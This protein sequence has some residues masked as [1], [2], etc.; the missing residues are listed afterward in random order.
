MDCCCRLSTRSVGAVYVGEHIACA[1][2]RDVSAVS[3]CWTWVRCSIETATGC[4]P[5]SR[6]FVP[7][8]F[9]ISSNAQTTTSVVRTAVT[10]GWLLEALDSNFRS[11]ISVVPVLLACRVLGGVTG[12]TSGLASG[13]DVLSDYMWSDVCGWGMRR[14]Y[15]VA[16]WGGAYAVVSVAPSKVVARM[17]VNHTNINSTKCTHNHSDVC[18]SRNGSGSSIWM[19]GQ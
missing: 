2:S 3:C 17:D 10:V 4:S 15:A 9:H 6:L 13:S 8:S 18:R 19:Q 12:D 11:G 5:R 14:A 7:H 1:A 16:A